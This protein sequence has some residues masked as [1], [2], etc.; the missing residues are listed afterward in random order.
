MISKIVI[1]LWAIAF[2]GCCPC[3]KLATSEQDSVRIE[4]REL[5]RDR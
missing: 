4:V 3:R 5:T 2:V 1:A